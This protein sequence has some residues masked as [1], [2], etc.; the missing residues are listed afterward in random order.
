LSYNA[1]KEAF[2]GEHSHSLLLVDYDLLSQNPEKTI[3]LIYQFLEEEPF[4]HDFDHVQYDEPEFDQRLHTQGLHKVREKV[5]FRP[6]Q[7]ILPPD[8]FTKFYDL[9]FWTELSNS[10]ANVIVAQP[11]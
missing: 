1:L 3:S 2:Y 6:R 11:L 4:A 5:E 9:S 10:Q 7:T 8:L